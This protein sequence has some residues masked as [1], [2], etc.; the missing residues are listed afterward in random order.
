MDAQGLGNAAGL[1]IRVIGDRNQ[2]MFKPAVVER[3]LLLPHHAP[4]LS[5]FNEK[6]YQLF[7]GG[8]MLVRVPLLPTRLHS[9]NM[10]NYGHLYLVLLLLA[11]R[12][13][14]DPGAVSTFFH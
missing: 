13:P 10:L 2:R 11:L 7:Q 1:S 9:E 3:V 8:L 4:D 5:E 6:M 12:I 14:P